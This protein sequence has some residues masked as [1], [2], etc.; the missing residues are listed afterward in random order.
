[1][2]T[3]STCWPA[4]SLGAPRSPC[5]THATTPA[6]S[7]PTPTNSGCRPIGCFE[8]ARLARRFDVEQFVERDD[9]GR[10][11]IG[12]SGRIDAARDRQTPLAF[13]RQRAIDRED[14]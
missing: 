9:D 13:A 14:Q 11:I 5:A 10:V 7:P 6:P 3:S 4:P 2:A 8:R 12:T 1:M